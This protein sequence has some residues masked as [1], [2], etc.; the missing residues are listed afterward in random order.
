VLSGM[1]QRHTAVLA[2]LRHIL[3][4]G[5][6]DIGDETASLADPAHLSVSLSP[7]GGLSPPRFFMFHN[8]SLHDSANRSPICA[9]HVR[10]WV[11]R[12][13]PRPADAS[14]AWGCSLKRQQEV[15][16]VESRGGGGGLAALLVPLVVH[17]GQGSSGGIGKGAHPIREALVVDA[18]GVHQPKAVLEQRKNHFSAP[19]YLLLMALYIYCQSPR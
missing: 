10:A 4:T 9:E 15:Q 12:H 7:T 2:S 14:C 13:S 18:L 11:V 1:L 16:E 19:K 8:P 5:T 3:L 6:A 17:V